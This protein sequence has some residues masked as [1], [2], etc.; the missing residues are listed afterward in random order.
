MKNPPIVLDAILKGDGL[1]GGACAGASVHSKVTS[2]QNIA[3][4][5]WMSASP[6]MVELQASAPGDQ[7]G[8]RHAL[9]EKE[10]VGFD[11]AKFML[12]VCSA[13]VNYVIPELTPPT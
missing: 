11:D 13:F 5:A 8:I 6:S 3:K 10:Q 2:M 9:L 12:V 4:R 1:L 7:A